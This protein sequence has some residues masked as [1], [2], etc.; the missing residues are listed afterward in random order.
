MPEQLMQALASM[1]P[2]QAPPQ[3]PAQPV[4]PA[5]PE[6]VQQALAIMTEAGADPE[7]AKAALA[8]VPAVGKSI[9]ECAYAAATGFQTVLLQT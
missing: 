4:T 8:S 1:L 2:A 6:P 5:L 3:P 7:K 9:E